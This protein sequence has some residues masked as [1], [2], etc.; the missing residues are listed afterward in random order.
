MGLKTAKKTAI[1][2][3]PTVVCAAVLSCAFV[4][5]YYFSNASAADGWAVGLP[6]KFVLALL[7]LLSFLL[8]FGGLYLAF[9]AA[10]RALARGKDAGALGCC[11]ADRALA[12][13]KAKDAPA[14]SGIFGKALRMVQKR[15]FAAFFVMIAVC[16]LPYL[17]VYF[18]G[19]LPWDG[20][21]SM[22]QFI[23]DAPLQNHHPVL[24]N[25]LYAGLM[26]LGRVLY[27]DNL[28]LL[29]IVCF[30][31]LVS[32]AA[33][34][35][36]VKQLFEMGAPR[37][38]WLGSLAFFALFP[39]WG[40]NAPVAYKDTLFYGVFCWFVLCV[41]RFVLC[42]RDGVGGGVADDA[43]NAAGD[44]GHVPGGVRKLALMVLLASLAVC[45]TRNNGIYVV[46]PVLAVLLVVCIVARRRKGLPARLPALVA[47]VLGCVVLAYLLAFKA[48]Y[49]AMGIAAQ[50]NKEMLSVPFQ[51]TARCLLEHPDDVTPEERAAIDAVLPYDSLASAYIPDLSDPV[52]ES[53]RFEDGNVP[54]DALRS[55]LKAWL[56][57]GM[58]HPVT[59]LKAFVANTYAY[60]YPFVIVGPELSRPV[61]TTEN[62]GLPINKDFDVHCLAPDGIRTQVAVFF[63]TQM[64]MP[65]LEL[66][67]SPASYV[68]LLVI[69]S[70]YMF[71]TR[72]WW[73]LLVA[74]PA[75]LLLLTVL[76]GPLNGH[77]RYI[78]PIAAALPLYLGMIVAPARLRPA[79]ASEGAAPQV[80]CAGV[81][82]D[83]P[84][85]GSSQA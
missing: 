4:F 85:P 23:T 44:V 82:L 34:A 5:G 60:F 33:F 45:F 74:L 72:N 50:E 11:T 65:V 59:Y 83:V 9:R 52:K 17:V 18:P 78:L 42:L 69:L 49:P 7:L 46:A 39:I 66:V 24:M 12:R 53:V 79:C 37:W 56:S 81:G 47:G 67:F 75:W 29:L 40:M 1:R 10:D 36:A 55:Y 20:A 38:C 61:F 41:L 25:A 8:A 22:N 51:Q 76:A 54:P 64:H 58:R 16:W 48:I 6:G 27:S 13:G 71:R 32:A 57:M 35:A 30:Q 73:G 19:T 80:G 62:V 15:P 77:L 63:D 21:R 26:S 3:I 68:L 14:R 70:A 84:Q 43:A 31:Y 2:E 28:G